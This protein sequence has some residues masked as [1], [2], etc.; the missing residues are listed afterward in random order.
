MLPVRGGA[1]AYY[2]YPADGEEAIDP[3]SRIVVMDFEPPR[4]VL[5]TRFD[6]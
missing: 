4:T 5:V 6:G 2:A 1:E 3:G